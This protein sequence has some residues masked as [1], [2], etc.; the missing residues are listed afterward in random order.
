MIWT[1][2]TC[3]AVYVFLFGFVSSEPDDYDDLFG[4]D[5][6]TTTA[7]AVIP[8]PPP[9]KGV[10]RLPPKGTTRWPLGR[11]GKISVPVDD[12][13]DVE[14]PDGAKPRHPVLDLIEGAEKKWN[15]MVR[16]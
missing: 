2:L 15:E 14:P 8:T 11:S 1:F 4:E 3:T 5:T 10:S 7:Q 6:H 13:G 12:T 9:S 16:R